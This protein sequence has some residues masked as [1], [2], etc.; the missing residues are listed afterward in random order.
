MELLG[1]AIRQKLLKYKV[2]CLLVSKPELL[3]H[4]QSS[5]AVAWDFKDAAPVTILREENANKMIITVF[6][7]CPHPAQAPPI[8]GKLYSQVYRWFPT[9]KLIGYL[10]H[11]RSE[12]ILSAIQRIQCIVPQPLSVNGTSARLIAFSL[13]PPRLN[14]HCKTN[15]WWCHQ[16]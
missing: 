1:Y 4:I 5:T 6:L 16:L 3:F 8:C 12:D 7:W 9:T 11:G 2:K 13:P 15:L 10:L 14:Q